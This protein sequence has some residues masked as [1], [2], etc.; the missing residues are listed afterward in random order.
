[1]RTDN[2]Q[3]DYKQLRFVGWRSWTHAINR[4]DSQDD[5]GKSHGFAMVCIPLW[6]FLRYDTG[7]QESSRQTASQ[8]S[9]VQ[10]VAG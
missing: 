4:S 10:L 9:H 5:V 7:T 6:Q 8:I 2:H 3:D 1:M